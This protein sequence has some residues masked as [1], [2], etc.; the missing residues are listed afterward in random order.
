MPSISKL[1]SIVGWPTSAESV[2]TKVIECAGQAFVKW[3]ADRLGI[4][5]VPELVAEHNDGDN[6]GGEI[7]GEAPKKPIDLLSVSSK[8]LAKLT[9]YQCLGNLPL[10]ATAEQVKKAYHKACLQYHPDKTGR[11]EDDEVFLKIKAGFDTLTD[12]QKRRAYDSQMP[13]DD[14]VPKGNETPDEFFAVYAPVFTRNLRFDDRLNPDRKQAA[15]NSSNN[16]GNSNKKN[17]KKAGARPPQQQPPSPPPLGD[18]DT[19]LDQ[20]HA[21][22]E[23]WTRF[24]SWRDFSMEAAKLTNNQNFDADNVDSR[25]EKRHIQKEI[26]RKAKALKREEVARVTLLVERA[27]AADP[28]LKREK[29]KAQV[30]KERIERDRKELAEKKEREEREQKE[31]AKKESEDKEARERE[32]KALEKANKEKQKKMMRKA[33][34]SLRKVC[35]AA[36]ATGKTYWTSM[37]HM[38]DDVEYLCEV[39]DAEA[40]GELSVAMGDV[41]NPILEGV[42]AIHNKVMMLKEGKSQ[43]E[44]NMAVKLDQEKRGGQNGASNGHSNGGV[45]LNPWSEAQDSQLQEGLAKYPS[46]MDKNERWDSIAKGVEGKTKKECVERFKAIREALKTKK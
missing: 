21:F 32:S 24:E 8:K 11:G 38:Y 33:K 7:N 16:N 1:A 23:Y 31:K 10:H 43:E 37:E 30:E 2:P 27:M 5:D 22:Y 45:T 25:F 34:A 42:D 12:K 28:R 26:D 14:S 19:P 46:T 17:R 20:V 18:K 44:A 35:L 41:D 9:Y 13:F 29:I 4:V 36:Q 6:P 40:L 15:T 39:L 3:E